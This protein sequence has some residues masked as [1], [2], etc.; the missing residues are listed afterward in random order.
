MSL[1]V[2]AAK[3]V[4]GPNFSIEQ[5]QIPENEQERNPDLFSI[6]K[7][8]KMGPQDYDPIYQGKKSPQVVLKSATAVDASGSVK[9]KMEN[10]LGNIF[11]QG[12]VDRQKKVQSEMPSTTEPTSLEK[13]KP[14]AV[15]KRDMTFHSIIRRDPLKPTRE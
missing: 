9:K 13:I 10:Y 4:L 1:G 5:P 3:L 7:M 8:N 6:Q 2:G 15:D 11:D 12:A 14:F